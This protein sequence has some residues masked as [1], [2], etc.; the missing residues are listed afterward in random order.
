VALLVSI[1]AGCGDAPPPADTPA[2]GSGSIGEAAPLADEPERVERPSLEGRALGPVAFAGET[3]LATSVAPGP[4]LP[5]CVPAEPVVRRFLSVG[6]ASQAPG[7]TARLV[8]EGAAPV[9]TLRFDATPWGGT[10]EAVAPAFTA[11]ARDAV[12]YERAFS[13]TS[14]TRPAVATLLTGV[15]PARHG[16]FDRQ[17][18]LAASVPRLPERLAEAGWTHREGLARLGPTLDGIVAAEADA[19]LFLYVHD[20]GPHAPWSPP[21]AT[22]PLYAELDLDGRRA[23]SVVRWPWK[24]LDQQDV[25]P[26]LFDLAADPG[27]RT[28][29]TGAAPEV[30]EQLRAAA[31]ALRERL[32]ALG[33]LEE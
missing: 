14:W 27:E 2:P 18:R 23:E 17:D 9:D 19:P 11:F 13:V 6:V 4:G 29:A 25:G 10:P 1:V 7:A 16:V 3:R 26:R 28:D 24:Y 33:Y 30:A 22:T 31:E 20:N 12:L 15:G 32:R 21:A 8:R 5:V